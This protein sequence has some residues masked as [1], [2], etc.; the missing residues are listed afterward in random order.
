MGDADRIAAIARGAREEATS[1]LDAA[2]AR[3][4]DVLDRLNVGD[5]AAV[6]SEIRRLIGETLDLIRAVAHLREPTLRTRDDLIAAG[7]KLSARLLAAAL[8]STGA[9]AKAI[10]ADTFL[11]TDD[12][13]GEANALVGISDRT[14]AAALRPPL[15]RGEIPV[16]TGFCGRA[17]DARKLAAAGVIGRGERVCGILTWHLLRDSEIVVDYHRGALP[18]ITSNFANALRRSAP[19]LTAVI[20]AMG[21]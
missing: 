2:L 21:D 16:V 7:E 13:F 1:L 14:I 6:E 15:D 11:E 3:H 10:D 9:A 20:S 5:R 8:E 18:G 12:R 19:T 17:P 4:L